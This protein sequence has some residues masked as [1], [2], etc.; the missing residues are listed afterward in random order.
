MKRWGWVVVLF[1]G[2]A[3]AGSGRP[4]H[5]ELNVDGVDETMAK[6]I[7]KEMAANPGVKSVKLRSLNAGVAIYEVEY[8]GDAAALQQALA[9]M[10]KPSLSTPRVTV[11][12]FASAADTEAPPVAIHYPHRDEVLLKKKINAVAQV[13]GQDVKEV[14]INGQV[15]KAYRGSLYRAALDLIEGPNEVVVAAVDNRGNRTV[16]KIKVTVDSTP[17]SISTHEKV[18]V[19]GDGTLDETYLVEGT[20]ATIF[21]GNHWRVELMVPKGQSQVEVVKMDAQ[22][23]VSILRKPAER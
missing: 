4:M 2:C 19:S 17:I 18:A 14:L 6:D 23:K 5:V 20:P 13:D 3:T 22:G 16:Q 7:Q 11:Q 12:A 9:G 1:L 8:A 21:T 10:K 15:T